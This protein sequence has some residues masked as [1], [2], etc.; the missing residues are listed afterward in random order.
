EELLPPG[1]RPASGRA[2]D[3]RD[4]AIELVDGERGL[5]RRFAVDAVDGRVADADAALPGNARQEARRDRDLVR[6]Q[7]PQQLR[8]DRNLS[9]ARARVGDLAR[10]ADDVCDE[11]HGTP[12][13]G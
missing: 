9:R 2:L 3:L 8:E 12:Q 11:G 1:G 6:L 10:G 4:R 7:P 5:L 13:A